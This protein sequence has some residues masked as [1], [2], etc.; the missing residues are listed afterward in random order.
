ML[1]ICAITVMLNLT[2]IPWTPKDYKTKD[3][4]VK[5]CKKERRCLVKFVKK[6]GIHYYAICGRVM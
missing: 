2:N 6:E 4:S 5:R 1:Y 3:R